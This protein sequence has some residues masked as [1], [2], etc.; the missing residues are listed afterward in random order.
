MKRAEYEFATEACLSLCCGDS[1]S[2]AEY[3]RKPYLFVAVVW[4]I[5][6]C[7]S[8]NTKFFYFISF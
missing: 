1:G 3:K 5:Q 6:T 7:G 2:T 8:G 4:S